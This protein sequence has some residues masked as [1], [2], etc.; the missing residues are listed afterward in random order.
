MRRVAVTGQRLRVGSWDSPCWQSCV[1]PY[2]R[3][4]RMQLLETCRDWRRPGQ[5]RRQGM[6]KSAHR[7]R[8]RVGWSNLIFEGKEEVA[9]VG[10]MRMQQGL[11][12]L[13]WESSCL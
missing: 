1:R 10:R 7:R 4:W 6:C 12:T 2:C 3:E 5:E 11:E 13:G 8:F 9:V